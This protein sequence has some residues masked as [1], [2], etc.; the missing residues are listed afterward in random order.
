MLTTAEAAKRLKVSPRRVLALVT[1]GRLP[2]QK[3][4]HVWMIAPADL[5]K[6]RNRKAGRPKS[7][8]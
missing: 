7:K 6:V 8:R 4:G 2:A 5:A 3:F 1:S